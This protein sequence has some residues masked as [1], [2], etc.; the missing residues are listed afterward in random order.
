MR[1]D[2]YQV[3]CRQTVR[4]REGECPNGP[5]RAMCPYTL[6]AMNRAYELGMNNSVEIEV[7]YA[8]PSSACWRPW[9]LFRM[10]LAV[11]ITQAKLLVPNTY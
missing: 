3:H 8:T 9:C 1:H 2:V 10:R 11:V 6:G 4:M 5:Q 7:G